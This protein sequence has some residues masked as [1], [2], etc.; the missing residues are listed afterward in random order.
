MAVNE[1][2]SLPNF[3]RSSFHKLLRS[4]N[5]VY[6]K[7]QRNCALLERND[8]VSWRRRYLDKIK[9]YRQQCR[10]IYYLD[11]TWVNAGETTKKSWVDQ[12]VSSSRDAFI[13]GL[14]TGQKEPSGKGKRLI[15]FHIGSS[16]GFVP[17]G[18]LCFESKTNSADYHNEMNGNTFYH[19]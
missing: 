7:K 17:G 9:H 3:K 12:T 5:F 1:D 4:M 2:E 16:D 10:P 11:E 14:T 8:I 19:L 13:K 6:K 15:V 18:L